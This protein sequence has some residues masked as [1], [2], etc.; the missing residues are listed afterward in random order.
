M[1]GI[2]A[3]VLPVVGAAPGGAIALLLGGVSIWWLL[4]GAALSVLGFGVGMQIASRN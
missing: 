3:I 4:I 1:K 2:I